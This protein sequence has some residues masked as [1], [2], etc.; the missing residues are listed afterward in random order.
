MKKILTTL[1]LL[2]LVS[3]LP[4]VAS[5]TTYHYI[6]I[7]GEV[8]S[9]EAQ[10][11]LDAL[12]FVN[13]QSNTLHTGVA[14]DRGLLNDGEVFAQTYNYVDK[15]YNLREVTAATSKAAF[16]LATDIAPNSG[17]IITGTVQE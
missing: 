11:A 6:T 15:N 12:N 2:S 10:N 5:A 9:V 4:G 7:D 13:N 17:I 1:G 8:E 16:I 14:I 3:V